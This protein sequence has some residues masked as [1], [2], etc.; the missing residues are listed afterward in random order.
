MGNRASS[1]GKTVFRLR[2]NVL[3]IFLLLGWGL[4]SA[5]SGTITIETQT[6]ATLTDADL[7]TRVVLINQGDET[8]RSI[9]C[10]VTF[11]GKTEKPPLI[12]ALPPKTPI[13]LKTTH[14]LIERKPGQYPLIVRVQFHDTNQY[15]FTA[16]SALIVNAYVHASNDLAIEAKD[17]A[18]DRKGDLTFRIKNLAEEDRSLSYWVLVPREL[19]VGAG[20]GRLSLEKRSEQTVVVRL[21]NFAALYGAAYPVY[22]FFEYDT[23]EAHHCQMASTTVQIVMEPS[24]FQKTRLYWGIAALLVLAVTLYRFLVRGKPGKP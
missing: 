4:T 5:F 20:E 11:Q 21:E 13:S 15:P 3:C 6:E 7:A 16:L 18:F 2:A 1:A 8:A 19:S 10:E 14:A 9:T 24:W 22:A 12:E 17:I 23:P